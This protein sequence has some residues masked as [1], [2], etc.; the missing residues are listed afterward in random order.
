MKVK[1]IPDGY[2]QVIPY[3]VV[4]DPSAVIAFLKATFKGKLVEEMKG[5]DGLTNHAEVRI[6]D[7]VVMMGR[8]R[9]PRKPMTAMLYV[10]VKD[11]DATY[12]AALKA[13][14]V[15]VMAPMDQFYGDRSGAVRDSAG[16][17]WWMASRKENLSSTELKKRAKVAG[18]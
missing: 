2:Q 16:N 7:S 6:G 17:E 1:A 14:G 13:G 5:K 11:A 3:L 18:K 8:A 9:E 10:Y 15:S 4:A 12:K